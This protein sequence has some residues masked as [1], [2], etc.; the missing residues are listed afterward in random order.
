LLDTGLLKHVSGT[1][2]WNSP[3]LSNARQTL[4]EDRNNGARQG[5]IYYYFTRPRQTG[6][7]T[8]GHNIILTLTVTRRSR[9]E[10]GSNTSTVALRIVG[11]DEKGSLESDSKKWS[12][13]SRDSDARM[14]ALVMASSIYKR[15]T[16]LLVRENAP[17]QQTRNYLTAIKIWS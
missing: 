15:Q 7:M 13:V 1:T 9:V 11:G 4:P 10:V 16:R 12:R 5:I 17:H 14:T 6:R 2:S 8:V 3:L